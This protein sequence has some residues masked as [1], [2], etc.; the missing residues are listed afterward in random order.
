VL[1]FSKHAISYWKIIINKY[2][3]VLIVHLIFLLGSIEQ[4]HNIQ[5]K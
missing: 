5:N 3:E 2:V 1:N 4:T